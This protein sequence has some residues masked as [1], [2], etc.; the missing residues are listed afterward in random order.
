MQIATDSPDVTYGRIENV[1]HSEQSDSRPTRMTKYHSPIMHAGTLSEDENMH[2]DAFNLPS[3]QMMSVEAAHN[4]MMEVVR[5]RDAMEMEPVNSSTVPTSQA[6]F[7]DG[8][9]RSSITTSNTQY[10]V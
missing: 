5:E 4:R 3:T 6:Q 1:Q 7:T 8:I 9:E 10:N 2:L